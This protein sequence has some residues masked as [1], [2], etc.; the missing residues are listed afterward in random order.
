MSELQAVVCFDSLDGELPHTFFSFCPF[1]LCCRPRQ[2]ASRGTQVPQRVPHWYGTRQPSAQPK[3]PPWAG[4]GPFWYI[5]RILCSSAPLSLSQDT[6]AAQLAQIEQAWEA[7]QLPSHKCGPA[8]ALERLLVCLSCAL[9][10]QADATRCAHACRIRSLTLVTGGY[11]LL[12]PRQRPLLAAARAPRTQSGRV[13]DHMCISPLSSW[14]CQVGYPI[15]CA[16]R[17]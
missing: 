14:I 6:A 11:G 9:A 2:P 3:S 4:T 12:Q 8:K 16:F 13:P 17:H 15:V 7:T 5:H 10:S 1:V